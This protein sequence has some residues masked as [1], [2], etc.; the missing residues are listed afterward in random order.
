MENRSVPFLPFLRGWL[1]AVAVILAFHAGP[2]WTQPG[3]VPEIA[4]GKPAPEFSVMDENGQ[5]RRLSE[6]RGAHVVL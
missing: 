2:A 3:Q 4:I 1:I 5:R 6:Y